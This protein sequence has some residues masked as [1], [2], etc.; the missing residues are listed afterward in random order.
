MCRPPWESTLPSVREQRGPSQG[1]S[2]RAWERG[3]GTGSARARADVLEHGARLDGSPAGRYRAAPGPRPPARASVPTLAP[4]AG[5]CG[6]PGGPGLAPWGG[7]SGRGQS[8][9]PDTAPIRGV[10][11]G[12]EGTNEIRLNLRSEPHK[13]GSHRNCFQQFPFR[14]KKITNKTNKT[15]PRCIHGG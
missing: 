5:K 10:G 14:R 11:E 6:G 1:D 9:G 8:L 7:G 3:H 12:A 15:S 13:G 4:R 2:W